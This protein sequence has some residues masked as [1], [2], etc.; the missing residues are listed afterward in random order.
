MKAILALTLLALTTTALADGHHHYPGGY[1]ERG[2]VYYTHD[3]HSNVDWMAP[4]VIGGVVGY[5]LAQPKTTVIQQPQVIV[6]AEPTPVY[7]WQTIFDESCSCQK[8]VLVKIN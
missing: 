3:H 7:Q 8:R 2:G 4:M 5:V 6:P 1:I